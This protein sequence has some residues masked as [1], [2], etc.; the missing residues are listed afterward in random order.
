MNKKEFKKFYKEYIK[1]FHSNYRL[2]DL[3]FDTTM[4]MRGMSEEEFREQM[5]VLEAEDKARV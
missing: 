2:L 3:N 4:K 5:S 1:N